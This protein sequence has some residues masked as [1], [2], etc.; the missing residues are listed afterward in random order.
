[1]QVMASSLSVVQLSIV[2][3]DLHPPPQW[4][5][6]RLLDALCDR[7]EACLTYPMSH[8]LMLAL[9]LSAVSAGVPVTAPTQTSDTAARNQVCSLFHL[10]LSCPCIKHADFGCA[11]DLVAAE[12]CCP[13]D[14]IAAEP[15]WSCVDCC[16]VCNC[17]S[18]APNDVLLSPPTECVSAQHGRA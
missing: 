8:D 2:E 6:D 7:L 16:I 3:P 10:N 9:L 18:Y 15:V 1:M 14:L 11:A 5:Q 13:V 12:F 17:C 4:N